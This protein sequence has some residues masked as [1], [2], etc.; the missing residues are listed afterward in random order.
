MLNPDQK[1]LILARKFVLEGKFAEAHKLLKDFEEQKNNSL[2]DIVSCHLI[3]CNLLLNQGLPKK[4]IEF[5]EQTYKES[6]GLGKSILSVD[7]L[8]FMANGFGENLNRQQAT[9]IAKQAEDLLKTITEESADNK[10]RREA[11]II[12]RKGASSN[13]A[14]SPEGD[15]DLAIKYYT[16]SLAM[17]ESLGDKELV[18]LSLNVIAWQIGLF[19]GNFNLALEHVERAIDIAEEIN[20][21]YYIAWCYLTKATLYHN[22]GEISRS[23]PFYEQSLAIAKDLNNE[24]LIT[25]NLNNMADAYRMSGD[26]EH[27][28]ECSKQSIAQFS[29]IDNLYRVF[30]L[31]DSL[32][33]ILIEKGDLE[34]AQRYF[35]HL[36][37]LSNQLNDKSINLSFLYNKALILKESR[38]ISNKGKSEEILK[39]ILKEKGI[40]WELKE[41]AILALCDLLLTEFQITNELE[42]LFEIKSL[43][44]QLFDIAE[45]SN[46]FWI[47][48][49]TYLLNAYLSLITINLKEARKYLTE[50][51]QIAEKYGLKLLARKISSEHDLLLR[52][53]D[54]WENLN[55]SA[56]PFSKR[57]ELS[58]LDSQMNNML[59]KQ[60]VEIPEISD[61]EPIFL[62][63]MSEGGKPILTQFFTASN[64][65]EDHLFGGFMSAINS[66]MDE[67]FSEGL[68]RA[69]FGQHTL[70][71]KSI[72]PFLVCYVYK[73]QSYSAQNRINYFIDKMQKDVEVWEIFHN[74][75][76][77][78]KEVQL[79]DIP[80]LDSLIKKVFIEKKVSLT[81]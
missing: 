5:A 10:A 71:M 7:A 2:Y 18:C 56:V 39:K 60:V 17:A 47:L 27:A 74:Y 72:I 48:G 45:K 30:W 26:L 79:N 65:F 14:F 43:I 22:K 41:R 44:A 68:D 80:Q 42:V 69:S 54:M 32:I 55:E 53:L 40:I 31:N 15:V 20:Y 58:R 1:E 49:E 6:L 35:K 28:L 73:G 37:K 78:N 19:K 51:Q 3:M 4:V 9:V 8:L 67:M 34:Q 63:I 12:F 24:R 76:K 66:F 13:P 61:E 62:L 59:R 33:Q 50:G 64:V 75:Y 21:K 16:Q 70:L 46:S 57:V 29:E 11:R 81:E 52:K 77:T 25:A 23:I 36:E 38:R